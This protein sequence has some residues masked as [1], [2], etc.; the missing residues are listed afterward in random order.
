MTETKESVRRKRP[1]NKSLK[2]ILVL[3]VSIAIVGVVVYSFLGINNKT[4]KVEG[5]FALQPMMEKWAAEYQKI[6][7]DIKIDI[8]ANGAGAG[9]VDA[10]KGIADIGMVSR[11]INNSEISQ[12]AFWI[13]VA[14]DAVVATMNANNPVR[15]ILLARGVTKQQFKDIFITGG[16][17]TWGQLVGDDS[18]T[19]KIIVYTRSDACGAADTWAKFMGS[20]V[21]NDLGSG[22]GFT[23][24]GATRIAGING[25]N[26][27]VAAV[28]RDRFSIGY[29]NT[30]YVYTKRLADN[31]VVPADGVL[32]VP[33]DLNGNGTL[34]SN[35][36]VYANRSSIVDAIINN[37][38][39][40]PP[41]RVENLVTLHSFSGIA[42]D[43][44]RWI[45]TDGQQYV[46]DAGYVPLPQETI[47]LELQYL[48]NGTRPEI[49]Q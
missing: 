5:A 33:I 46:L 48:E 20:Y 30:G 45:L 27:L 12:G 26:A 32:P 16:I 10:L 3:I 44:V 39:P 47:A 6:H 18:I 36:S 19:D 17:S 15:E 23:G 43:F 38:Y 40:S 35:E 31:T 8:N 28:Q 22:S 1:M 29:D 14:K 25:D 37:V 21:Q 13:S 11:A 4:I 41:A 7:P 34:E 24:E 49:S 9:M 2:T 42:K